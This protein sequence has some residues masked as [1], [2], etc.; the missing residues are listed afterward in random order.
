MQKKE[1]SK[2]CVRMC[3]GFVTGLTSSWP[4]PK[5][6]P[7]HDLSSA[8]CLVFDPSLFSLPTQRRPRQIFFSVLLQQREIGDGIPRSYSCF[9]SSPHTPPPLLLTPRIPQSSPKRDS[10][11]PRRD[12][13]RCLSNRR[14][15]VLC[16]VLPRKRSQ[17]ET[18]A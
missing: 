17:R 7:T 3:F 16:R 12:R 6:P 15:V 18:R 10:Q 9:L 14:S 5:P 11:A 2:T 8:A 13:V 1:K 4:R